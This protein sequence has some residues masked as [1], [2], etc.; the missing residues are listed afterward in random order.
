MGVT[1]AISH[2]DDDSTIATAVD[3]EPFVLVHGFTQNRAST[4]G[5]LSKA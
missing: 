5:N 4:A 3:R 2:L 1:L